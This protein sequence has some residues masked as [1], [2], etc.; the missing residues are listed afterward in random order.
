MNTV[1]LR[2]KWL[3][4]VMYVVKKISSPIYVTFYLHSVT[5]VRVSEVTKV[6]DEVGIYQLDCFY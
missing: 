1:Y 6:I 4:Q 5:S 3:Y 2:N